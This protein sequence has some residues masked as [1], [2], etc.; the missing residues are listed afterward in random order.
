MK[1]LGWP[2][3]ALSSG[4]LV[5]VVGVASIG[6]NTDF[7]SPPRY[8]G[9]GYAVLGQALETGRGYREIQGP[10][11]VRHTHYPPGYPLA[12]AAT[13]RIAGRSVEAAHALSVA[14]S[15]GAILAGWWWFRSIYSERVALAAGLA[16]AANWSWGRVGGAIQSE[17]LYLLLGQLAILAASW[18]GRRG[19]VGPGLVVGLLLGACVLT[20]HVGAA[21][22]VAVGLD[23]I[24]RRRASS[25]VAA[26]LATLI[27]VGPWIGWLAASRR[28]TQVDL[29]DGGGLASLVASQ[30][31]FYVRR[32]PDHWVGPIVEIG[33][34][35]ANS[36]TLF[37]L[38]HGW[39]FAA[40]G[41]IGWGWWR[42]LRSP[43][44]RLAG[45]VPLAT[46]PLLLAWPFTEAGRFL[47]PL[48]PCLIVGTVEGL[49][50]VGA[51]VRLGHPRAWAACAVLGASLLYP[52]YSLATGGAE[53]R[54]RADRPFD[55]ACDWIARR[56]DRPGPVLSGHPAEVFWRT[57][58]AGMAPGSD[59]T[60]EID[61]S[62]D[63]LGVAYL[64]VDDR[65]YARSPT[66]PLGRYVRLRPDRVRPVWSGAEGSAAV[67]VFEVRAPG[68]DGGPASDTVR[69]RLW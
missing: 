40:S 10:T 39:A 57:G 11:P 44:K 64:I 25:L 62:I 18:A 41:L 33:T 27:L 43:G 14:C 36:T 60:G 22:A 26:G 5:A 35:F 56:G 7:S 65:R 2:G 47:I 45:L 42:L 20:R 4:L 30:G 23:L 8:D 52:G 69:R 66:S 12:L 46:F 1:S 34:V 32:L 67:A 17:P 29:F 15:V 55:A 61:R 31:L 28:P 24:L 37:V 38:V 51:R 68:G 49:A 13:W 16:L 48:V 63:R 53:A 54:R 50:A 58:R 19:G 21:L 6:S 59:D 9:A 3:R